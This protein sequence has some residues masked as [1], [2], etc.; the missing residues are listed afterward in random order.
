MG[1]LTSNQHCWKA[2]MR[3]SLD[4]LLPR[5]NSQMPAMF[6]AMPPRKY[7]EPEMELKDSGPEPRHCIRTIIVV[8]KGIKKPM[9]PS[10]V[11]LPR[12]FAKS[13]RGGADGWKKSLSY[14]SGVNCNVTVRV[15]LSPL[16]PLSKVS[17]MLELVPFTRNCIARYITLGKRCR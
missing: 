16:E 1:K 14:C 6:I 8:V 3:L 17:V 10:N 2:S 7:Q 5:M 9:V 12:R 13:P 4:S 15:K 11:G